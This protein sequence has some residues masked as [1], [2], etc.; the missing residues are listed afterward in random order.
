MA[1]HSFT[2]LRNGEEESGGG[3]ISI[4]FVDHVA[5]GAYQIFLNLRGE[6]LSIGSILHSSA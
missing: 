3:G 4:H 2:G 5:V 6:T 1:E